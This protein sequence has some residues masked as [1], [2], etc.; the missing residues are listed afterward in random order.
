MTFMRKLERL[1]LEH[2][3]E[4]FGPADYGLGVILITMAVKLWPGSIRN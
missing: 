1:V 2:R 3:Y 4:M